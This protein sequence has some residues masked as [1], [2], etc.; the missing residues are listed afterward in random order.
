MFY[1]TV[2][3]TASNLQLIPFTLVCGNLSK[4]LPPYTASFPAP[5]WGAHSMSLYSCHHL[6]VPPGAP[7]L[8]G[9]TCTVLGMEVLA[10]KSARKCWQAWGI[11]HTMNYRSVG[12]VRNENFITNENFSARTGRIFSVF[13]HFMA[14]LNCSLHKGRAVKRRWKEWTRRVFTS[15]V[16]TGNWLRAVL[17]RC[18][19]HTDF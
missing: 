15:R 5:F 6:L 4:H 17:S 10:L 1:P 7:G 19:I 13:P 8:Q 14:P 16:V 3:K 12:P 2:L 9:D 11:C 18:L